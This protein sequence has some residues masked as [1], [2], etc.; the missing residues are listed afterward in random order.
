MVVYKIS[1]RYFFIYKKIKHH[2]FK[3]FLNLNI[4]LKILYIFKLP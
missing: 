4:F 2:V 3:N 1:D